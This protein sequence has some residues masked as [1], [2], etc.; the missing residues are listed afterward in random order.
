VR[1]IAMAERR[2]RGRC[3]G[4]TICRSRELHFARPAAPRQHIPLCDLAQ[5]LRLEFL[6]DKTISA[7]PNNADAAPFDD[8]LAGATPEWLAVPLRQASVNKFIYR[9]QA[10]ETAA[11]LCLRPIG[12]RLA[13]HTK[14]GAV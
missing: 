11:C 1:A 2:Q 3:V 8:L 6:L 14:K 5:P 13:P 9:G 4:A 7:D 10:A 12:H